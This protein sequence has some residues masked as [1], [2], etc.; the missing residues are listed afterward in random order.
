MKWR[1]T[2]RLEDTLDEEKEA[3]SKLTEIAESMVNNRAM[4]ESRESG[5]RT[6]S[7]GSG[8]GQL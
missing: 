1:A 8:S 7:A 4:T 6:G 3:D 2:G 5:A